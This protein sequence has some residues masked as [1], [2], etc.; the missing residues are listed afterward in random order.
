MG[1]SCVIL[2]A[3]IINHVMTRD[4]TCDIFGVDEILCNPIMPRK[5]QAARASARNIQIANQRHIE[6]DQS[7]SVQYH[8]KKA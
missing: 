2:A 6:R 3:Y 1:F 5:K 8:H 7:E 4:Y